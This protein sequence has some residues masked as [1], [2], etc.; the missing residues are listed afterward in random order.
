MIPS[1]ARRRIS[2]AHVAHPRRVEAGGGLVEDQ[3]ARAAQQRGGDAQALAHPVGVAAHAVLR[4][5]GQLDDLEHLVDPLP[6]AATVERGEQFEVLAS[7]QVGVEARRLHEPRDALQRA[8]AVA[9]RVAPEQLDGALRRHDQAE[10]HAQ[11]GRLAGAVGAEEPVDVAGVDVQVDVV[12]REDLLV[13]LDQPP[14]RE[15][16]PPSSAAVTGGASVTLQALGDR[17]DGGR[18]DRAGEQVAHAGALEAEQRAELGR[19]LA[20]A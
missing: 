19:Q 5:R 18:G 7:R 2:S 12:D 20:G 14:A 6:R 11:R 13:A 17:F 15:P 4:P 10:R 3:Q 8:R 16:A 1:S 9:H